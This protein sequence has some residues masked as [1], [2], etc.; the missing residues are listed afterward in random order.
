MSRVPASLNVDDLEAAITFYLL[1]NA[2]LRQN[3]S[4]IRQL[5]RRSVSLERLGEPWHR[6]YC[7]LSR[8]GSRLEQHR[9]A[10]SPA[11]LKLTGYR[12]G[13][14]HHVLLCHPGQG[15]TGSAVT[16]V[17]VIPAW[18]TPTF[19]S[20]PPPTDTMTAK[21]ACAATGCRRWRKRPTVPDP[22]VRLLPRSFQF[23]GHQCP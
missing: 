20:G 17:E 21:Q 1:F 18:P 13:D 2:E 23:L 7:K 10:E 4:P 5:H 3:A 15:G 22:G 9:Y 19:G 6:R 14:R 11:G 16:A 12:E 8:C